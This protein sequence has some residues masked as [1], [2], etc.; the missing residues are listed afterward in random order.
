MRFEPDLFDKLFSN[1]PDSPAVRTLSLEELKNSVAR[2]IESLLNTRMVFSEEKLAGFKECAKSILTY[3]LE[4]FSGKSL[5]SHEDRALICESIKRVIKR[6]EPRLK[7]ATVQLE[8]RIQS[9]SALHFSIKATL[10]VH[11][12]CEPVSFEAQLQPST[13]QYSV[14]RAG[15]RF[16]GAIDG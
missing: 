9:I 16:P 11:P 15:G 14:S 5:A 3:G 10:V 6:H 1:A 13:R 8:P 2:N 12:A 7:E 4:D